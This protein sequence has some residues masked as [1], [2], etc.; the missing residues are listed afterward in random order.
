MVALRH[1]VA[2]LP[3]GVK[4]APADL[5]RTNIYNGFISQNGWYTLAFN[6]AN[7]IAPNLAEASGEEYFTVSALAGFK[8]TAAVLATAKVQVWPLASASTSGIAAGMTYKAM[9]EVTFHLT[10]LYPVS[11]TWAQVYPGAPRLGAT[12][13]TIPATVTPINDTTPQERTVILREWSSFVPTEGQW[14]MEVLH[15]TPFGTERL[16]NVSFNVSKTIEIHGQ[17]YSSE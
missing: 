2:T 3:P 11:T 7:I 8:S 1:D 4:V 12:G 5:A 14:T 17:I 6:A 13:T 10:D 9:P 16:T 15:T